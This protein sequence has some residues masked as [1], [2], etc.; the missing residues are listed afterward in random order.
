MP[1]TSLDDV[2]LVNPSQVC[3]ATSQGIAQPEAELGVR[4][5]SG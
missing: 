4:L 5:P 3:P 1:G 2:L